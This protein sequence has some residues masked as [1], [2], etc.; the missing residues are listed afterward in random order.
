MHNIQ[1]F[2]NLQINK[3]MTFDKATKQWGLVLSNFH[4]G[5]SKL[6]VRLLLT[7]VRYNNS[8]SGHPPLFSWESAYRN[9]SRRQ[10]YSSQLRTLHP[11]PEGV[12]LQDC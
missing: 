10:T 9:N 4:S 2:L 7:R 6:S 3:N 11:I 12:H 1:F 8:K 5:E